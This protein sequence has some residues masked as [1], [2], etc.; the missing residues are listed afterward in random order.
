MD[1]RK[2]VLSYY[3]SAT[4][5]FYITRITHPTEATK[6]H[7]HNYFQAYY[8]QQGRLIH[9]IED[10]AAPLS[11]WDVFIL[12]PDISHYIEADGEGLAFY[13][14]SFM[15]GYFSGVHDGNKLIAD[16]LQYL[17][18]A[19]EKRI[20]PKLTL[21]NDDILFVDAVFKRILTEFQGS[22]KGKEE[23]IRECVSVLISLFAR[24]Y[25]EQKSESLNTEFNRQSVIYCIEYIRNHSDEDISLD[26]MARRCT[27][28]RT[29]FCTL[30]ASIAGMPFRKYVNSCRIERAAKLIH[31]GEKITTAS[32]LCGYSDFSTF[33]RNF[34]A[35]IGTSPTQY[36][37]ACTS[38]ASEAA[39]DIADA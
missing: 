28:S 36:Q 27:M 31:S 12:P 9:H 13:A 26:E 38:G 33:Y 18:S 21:P 19:A 34:R 7:S 6:L 24:I 30:F 15:P 3:E 39:P 1:V 17:K 11:T 5:D 25:F 32:T 2:F 4:E 22:K 16:F 8:V 23:L 35:V 29:T 37:N 10:A 20:Q 14:M